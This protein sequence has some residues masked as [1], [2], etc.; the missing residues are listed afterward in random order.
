L[1]I[2][3]AAVLAHS[4]TK[5]EAAEAYYEASLR[6]FEESGSQKRV[7]WAQGN[8]AGLA[9]ERNEPRHAIAIAESA[10]ANMREAG[11]MEG[12]A[13]V[14]RVVGEA[15]RMLGDL[16]VARSSLEECLSLSEE[17]GDDFAIARSHASLAE[18]KRAEGDAHASTDHFTKALRLSVSIGQKGFVSTILDDLAS[19][20]CESA[21]YERAY[22]IFAAAHAIRESAGLSLLPVNREAYER[23]LVKARLSFAD[24][25]E[26][27]RR[28]SIGSEMS[29]TEAVD[30]ALGG[31]R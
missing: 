30:Y 7:G 23:S 3:R 2:Y 13:A 10:L 16:N 22:T 9:I 29:M 25:T 5:L 4:Q 28:W 15:A 26:A 17:L 31:D 8:L 18:L 21:R 11:D 20:E 6:L 1:L 24:E 19:S 27:A 14:L 12:V